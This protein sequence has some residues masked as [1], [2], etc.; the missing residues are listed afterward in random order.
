MSEW[1]GKPRITEKDI[2]KAQPSLLEFFPILTRYF[3]NNQKMRVTAILS[4]EEAESLKAAITRAYG[5]FT[6]TNLQKAAHQAL[7]DWTAKNMGKE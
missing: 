4:D 2:E 7:A 1:L 6:P 5:S 3:V